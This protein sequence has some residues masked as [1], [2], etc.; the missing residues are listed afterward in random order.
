[1]KDHV[2]SYA[3]IFLPRS[4]SNMKWYQSNF[5]SERRRSHLST[6][7]GAARSKLTPIRAHVVGE[8]GLRGGRALVCGSVIIVSSCG[9]RTCR[10][11]GTRTTG[12]GARKAS[13][14]DAAAGE[15]TASA[16][17]RGW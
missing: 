12:A 5:E 10:R 13:R 3:L 8:Q 14:K 6:A 2:P 15:C 16:A 11:A 9:R 17:A 4:S 7:P 1:M